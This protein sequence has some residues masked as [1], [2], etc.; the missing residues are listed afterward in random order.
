MHDVK[1]KSGAAFI[2]NTCC[3]NKWKG[4]EEEERERETIVESVT[5]KHKE[6]GLE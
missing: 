6:E 2:K 1:L 4:G 5:K 3:D